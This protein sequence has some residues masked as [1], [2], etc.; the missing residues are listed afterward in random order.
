MK[1]NLFLFVAI[2]LLGACSVTN[3]ETPEIPQK[4]RLE[5]NAKNVNGMLVGVANK[6]S[7]T[8]DNTYKGWFNTNYENYSPNATIL[9]KLKKE[10]NGVEIRAYIGTWCPDSR[11]ELP[12]FYKIMDEIGF[13]DF[14][15]IAVNR[16]NQ[17]NGL[18]KGYDLKFVPTFILFK[19][20]KEIGRF[21]E[22]VVNGSLE[23]DL[24][25][26]ANPNTKT[27]KSRL[28]INAKNVNGMLVGVAN[29]ESFTNDNA[30]KGWFNTKYE[31]YSP[32]AD[33]LAKLKKAL[34]GVEIRCYMGT[35]CGDS[36]REVPRFY[37]IMDEIGFADFDMITVN[38]AKKAN[39]LEKG[40]HLNYVPTFI[41]FKNGKEIGRFVESVVKGSLENDLLLIASEKGY[42]HS[43][44]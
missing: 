44:E 37:K 42:K 32:K 26:I 19:N 7:F 3:N 28:E 24:L 10:L 8:N 29:K 18:E 17:A 30:Y 35:W 6:E 12:R 4:S 34:N 1:K 9:A 40:Y 41:L 39:G 33:I 38:R 25:L 23:N 14:D 21:V 22:S 15:M 20:G 5:I 36:R 16:D 43:R 2:V 13:T 27:Q 11:R 31:N